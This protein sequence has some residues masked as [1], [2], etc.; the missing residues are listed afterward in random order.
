MSKRELTI[1]ECQEKVVGE[2]ITLTAVMA[3]AVIAIVAVIVYRLFMSKEGSTTL[4][5]GFKF[6]WE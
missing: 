2:V 1:S 6:E 3:I 4:P 5:G